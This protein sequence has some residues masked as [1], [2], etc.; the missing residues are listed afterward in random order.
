MLLLNSFLLC[1]FSLG[2]YLIWFNKKN[3]FN[4]QLI[5]FCII[6]YIIPSIFFDFDIL[7]DNELFKT[8][9]YIN[10][11]GAI[12]YFIGLIVG[13][14]IEKITFINKT[15]KL[16]Y[17]EKFKDNNK[18][19]KQIIVISRRFYVFFLII[20]CLCFVYL[21]YIPIF[22]KDP[23]MAKQFKGV[24][25]EK[26]V[27]IALIY[28]TSKQIIQILLPFLLI[29][30]ILKKNIVD[31]FLS[32]IGTF[33][34]FASMSRGE[35]ATSYLFIFSI[36]ILLYRPKL[37]S[38]FLIFII[39]IFSFG[40]SFWVILGFIF[41]NSFFSQFTETDNIFNNLVI[42][43]A[44]DIL[45]H[46][47]FLKMFTEQNNPFTYGLTMI[48]GLIPFNFKY[49]PS[50]F[51]LYVLNQTDDITDI[52]SGGLRLPI[53]MWGYI[54]GGWFG[55]IIIPFFSALFTGYIVK[56][57]KNIFQYLRSNVNHAIIFYLF[58]FIIYYISILITN[59]Y[60]I[61]IYSIPA[62]FIYYIFYKSSKTFKN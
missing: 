16:D 42:F 36:L 30:G 52:A 4:I 10:L 51:T 58:I 28:R 57:I 38:F 45:D 43:G 41:P 31:I 55:V 17:W 22:A 7:F 39:F 49:S 8:Y 61:S 33:F 56:K 15:I 20:F 23:F 13:S 12:F 60:F 34:I 35:T 48:G 2:T 44:P 50:S 3:I 19:C 11:V 27:H 40:S 24:Y 5:G 37:F 18:F 25:H 29:N 1:F 32:L 26:Y 21:G 9:F 46:L 14:K 6:S 47:N 54:N 59:F 53:S 62:I